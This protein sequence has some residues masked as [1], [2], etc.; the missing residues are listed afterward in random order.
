[1]SSS[2]SSDHLADSSFDGEDDA[3]EEQPKETSPKGKRGRTKKQWS[4][5]SKEA[6][7]L[8]KTVVAGDC[9]PNDCSDFRKTVEESDTWVE[10]KRWGPNSADTLRRHCKSLVKRVHECPLTGNGQ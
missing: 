6:Q 7:L 1:M 10:E 3:S 5:K 9:D 4:D 8:V 2:D